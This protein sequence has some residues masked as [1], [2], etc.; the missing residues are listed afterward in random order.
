MRVERV[1]PEIEATQGVPASPHRPQPAR[2]DRSAECGQS[3]CY[4]GLI[5]LEERHHHRG[6]FAF[7]VDENSVTGGGPATDENSVTPGWSWASRLG[8]A[9]TQHTTLLHPLEVIF[10]LVLISS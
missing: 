6:W 8:L 10:V 1:G 9:C 2:T 5:T 3:V 4:Q 7:R